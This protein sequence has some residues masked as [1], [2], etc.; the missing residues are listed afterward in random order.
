VYDPGIDSTAYTPGFD[1]LDFFCEQWLS[2]E[3]P[4][5]CFYHGE[6][7]GSLL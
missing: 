4:G 2:A 1:S 5:E 3:N 7:Q 6:Q